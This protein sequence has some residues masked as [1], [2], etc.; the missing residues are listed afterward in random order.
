N[1][2]NCSGNDKKCINGVC[3]TGTWTVIYSSRPNK[4]SPWNCVYAYCFSDGSTST[5]TQTVTSSTM[6]PIQCY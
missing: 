4:S 5:Y 2:S 6:C 3:E 1:S